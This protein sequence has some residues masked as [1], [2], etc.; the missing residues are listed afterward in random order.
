MT[1]DPT[2]L[3]IVRAW[4]EDGSSEPLRA[5]IRLSTDLS[6]G[7]ERE[8]TLTQIDEVCDTVQQWLEGV[9]KRAGH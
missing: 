4:V 7:I 5:Q 9:L 8:L 6:I 2:G 1:N 3:L